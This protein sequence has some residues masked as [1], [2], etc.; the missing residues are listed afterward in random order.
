MPRRRRTWLIALIILVGL[1]MVVTRVGMHRAHTPDDE[2]RYVD[3]TELIMSSP[4][5]ALLPQRHADQIDLVFEI[6]RD[7][8]RNFSEWKPGSPITAVNEN[9]GGQ[10][11]EVPA[12][13]LALVRRSVEIGERTGGAFDITWAAL[14]GV[15]DFKADQPEIPSDEE[16]ARRAALVDFRRVQIDHGKRTIFLPEAGMKLGTGGVAKGY[17]LDRAAEALRARGVDS[18]LL[19]AAGQMAVAGMRG[20]RPWRIGIRDPRAPAD[21]YFA[22]LDVTDTTVST[23][24]DYERFFV[25]DGVRYH[26]ILDPGT[27][28]PVR[29]LRS[30][31][32]V[33]AD[34]ALADAISTAVMV[35]GRERGMALVEGLD[36][37]EAVLVDEDARVHVSSGL[38]G[39]L[40]IV[41]PPRP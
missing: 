3:A 4:I 9:A 25:R 38:E 14:W 40:N 5:T 31:T 19:S 15:W 16:L 18:F 20:D 13:V 1:A 23:S 2:P 22:F 28:R 7:V 8:D 39:K 12:E 11:I 6:F 21:D 36:A 34:G 10:P 29:G 32:I 27:G 41:H 24:G 33:C 26:H 35:L 17:A 30:T 37:V